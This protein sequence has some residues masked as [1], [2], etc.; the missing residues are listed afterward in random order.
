MEPL[1]F[2][3]NAAELRGPGRA[4]DVACGRG[5]HLALL[6]ARGF[7]VVGVDD[8]PEALES[9]RQVCPGATLIRRDV[10]ADGLGAE[11]GGPFDLVLTT[12]FLYRP[13]IPELFA[14]LK[15]G[16]SWWM[17]T[18]HV[19]NHLRAGKPRREAFC[20]Q[21][22]EAARL[23]EEAGFEV[24]SCE[25]GEHGGTWTTQLVARRPV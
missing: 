11:L 16:G 5:R 21:P 8:N 1:P 7:S 18:F 25:E 10:E 3:A 22:G 17:E 6:E 15:P 13:L 2:L 20:W 14:A 24:L 19:E 9:A 12:F 23:A 4:L